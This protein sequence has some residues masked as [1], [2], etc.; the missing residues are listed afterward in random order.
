MIN[1][2][3]ATANNYKAHFLQALSFRLSADSHQVRIYQFNSKKAEPLTVT[4]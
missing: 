3:A 4:A 1:A 2:V